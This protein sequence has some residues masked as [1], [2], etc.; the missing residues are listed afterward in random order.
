[1]NE[2][3]LVHKLLDLLKYKEMYQLESSK[4]PPSDMY[5]LERLYFNNPLKFADISK[6]Y[7]IPPSTLTGI[8]D[9]LEKK[10]LILRLRSIEDRR[11]IEIKVTDKGEEIIKK[12]IKEDECFINNLLDS[13]DINKREVFLSLL[14]ELICNT[15]KE[16]LFKEI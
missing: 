12:H 7:T 3:T 13:L 16:N 2:L 14:E 8:L 6:K 11:S 9:R 15:N 1:M 10:N 5:V 4:L